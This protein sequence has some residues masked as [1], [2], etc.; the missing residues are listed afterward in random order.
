MGTKITLY[1]RNHFVVRLNTQKNVQSLRPLCDDLRL[2]VVEGE[3]DVPK[4]FH[5]CISLRVTI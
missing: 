2:D 1:I 5:N 3:I 4:C